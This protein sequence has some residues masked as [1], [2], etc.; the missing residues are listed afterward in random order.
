MVEDSTDGHAECGVTAVAV[1]PSPLGNSGRACPFAVRTFRNPS[2][3]DHFQ[4]GSA[5]GIC[6]EQIVD[7]KRVGSAV[8]AC[9][10]VCSMDD[11]RWSVN[12]KALP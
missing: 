12:K 10:D 4:V 3:A 7:A 11:D 9:H 1:I 6:G 2:P 8:A 5:V